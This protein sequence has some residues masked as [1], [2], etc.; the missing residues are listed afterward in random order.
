MSAEQIPPDQHLHREQATGSGTFQPRQAKIVFGIQ[1]GHGSSNEEAVTNSPT[2]TSCGFLN[3]GCCVAQQTLPSIYYDFGLHCARGSRDNARVGIIIHPYTPMSTPAARDATYEDL[4]KVPD[5]L[6]AQIIHGQLITLPRPAP[7]HA[8][9]S[10]VLGA[11]I[12]GPFHTGRHGGPGSWW[13]LDEPELHLGRDILVPDL[14]GWRRERMPALPETAFFELPPDW[15]CEVL[16]P[17]T[18]QMDRVDKLALYAAHGVAHAWLVDPDA[19]TLE[20]FALRGGQWIFT[21]ALKESDEVCAPPF[22]AINF[23]LAALWA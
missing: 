6:V 11:E 14:A 7:R 9:A 18:A 13:I 16:S 5:H 2:A 15:I 12:G 3:G 22:D 19:K 23:S 4:C 8:L 21:L 20:V 10:S 17:A 1:G